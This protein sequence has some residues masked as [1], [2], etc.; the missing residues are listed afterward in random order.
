MASAATFASIPASSPPLPQ[1]RRETASPATTWARVRIT[2]ARVAVTR[3]G[4][5]NAA[6]IG[7]TSTSVESVSVPSRAST[8]SAN[9]LG[10]PPR[11]TD[12]LGGVT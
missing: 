1:T 7:A 6:S 4:S 8:S 5:A 12:H 3:A 11:T 2:S 10:S 9:A